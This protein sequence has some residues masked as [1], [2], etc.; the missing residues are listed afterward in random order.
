MKMTDLG[1]FSDPIPNDNPLTTVEME[2]LLSLQHTLLAETASSNSYMEILEKLCIMSEKIVLR[3]CASIMLLQTDNTLVVH[4]APNLPQ[5]AIDALAGLKSGEGSCGN[6]VFHNRAM[7]VTNTNTDARWENLQSFV[8]QFNV[9]ACWSCPIHKPGG[10]VIGS[11]ALS[12]SSVREPSLFQRR[13]LEIC[14]SVA[15]I[16]LQ[17]NTDLEELKTLAHFDHLTGVS[18]RAKFIEDASY[19]INQAWYRNENIAIAFIDLDR[20]KFINDNFGHI[21]GDQA[22]I[23]FGNNLRSIL[24]ERDIIGRWGGDEFVLI[25]HNVGESGTLDRVGSRLLNACKG[26]FHVE[27][28]KIDLTASIGLKLIDNK[29]IHLNELILLADKAMLL[30]KKQGG[31]C[32]EIY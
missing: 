3:S 20:F 21:I 13:V 4:T 28:H 27:E 9:G 10:A 25:L 12:S 6:A 19:L 5:A 16:I 23:L 1:L 24:R 15:G 31:D 11:F 14:A 7:Y 17:R 30:S 26:T 8:E 22:L 32:F 2:R 29:R 18:T